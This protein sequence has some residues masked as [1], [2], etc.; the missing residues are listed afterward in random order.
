MPAL[1]SV[2]RSPEVF[3]VRVRPRWF[4]PA[5]S[6]CDGVEAFPGQAFVA[7][8]SASVLVMFCCKSV[9]LMS[10]SDRCHSIPDS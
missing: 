5:P 4:Q 2:H 9:D 10:P 6:P 3:V 7:A 8:R 1:S